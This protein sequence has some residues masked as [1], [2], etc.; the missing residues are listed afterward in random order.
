MK[1]ATISR[2]KAWLD[3][4]KDIGCKQVNADYEE[5]FASN[6][7]SASEKK[8]PRAAIE[9]LGKS[10]AGKLQKDEQKPSALSQQD[11]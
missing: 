8:D 5:D 10:S 7:G 1:G 2:E 6:S 11:M 4:R 9:N 3:R